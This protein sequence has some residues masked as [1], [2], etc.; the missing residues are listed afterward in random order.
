MDEV[1][2]DSN[3]TKRLKV[4]LSLGVSLGIEAKL[5]NKIDHYIDKI[6]KA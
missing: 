4:V 3:L 5:S 1:L 6:K 2:V